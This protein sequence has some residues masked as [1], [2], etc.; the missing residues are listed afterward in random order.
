VTAAG[1]A[2]R[3]TFAAER[4]ARDCGGGVRTVEDGDESCRAGEGSRRRWG[5]WRAT[6]PTTAE[7]ERATEARA[8]A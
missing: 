8:A 1:D 7:V 5:R 2:A 3:E 6:R 4:V